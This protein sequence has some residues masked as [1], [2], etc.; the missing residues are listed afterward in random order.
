MGS[1][2]PQI[3][4]AGDE[5]QSRIDTLEVGCRPVQGGPKVAELRL[6]G[7]EVGAGSEFV[8]TLG[9]RRATAR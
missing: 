4:E 9:Q 2:V 7:V 3:V 6:E 5:E 1:D 8:D